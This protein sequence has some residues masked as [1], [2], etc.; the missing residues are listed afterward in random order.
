MASV[1]Y[2]QQERTNPE[3]IGQG[4][5]WTSKAILDILAKIRS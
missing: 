2:F 3:T 4:D 5:G 1:L